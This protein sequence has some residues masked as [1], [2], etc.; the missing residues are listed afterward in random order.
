MEEREAH[1]TNKYSINSKVFSRVVPRRVGT[2]KRIRNR[3]ETRLKED[4]PF[5]LGNC[6]TSPT[7]VILSPTPLSA[8]CSLFSKCFC[9]FA[10]L[11]SRETKL[12]RWYVT[13]YFNYVCTVE[14]FSRPSGRLILSRI[15]LDTCIGDLY[16]L[17]W[18]CKRKC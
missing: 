17:L 8:P 18:Y 15:L 4:S 2:T 5:T 7:V 14:S 9:Y 13:D 6:E 10:S 16:F 3:S 11:E 1:R 12:F